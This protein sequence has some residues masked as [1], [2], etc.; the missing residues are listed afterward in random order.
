MINI[1]EET[2]QFLDQIIASIEKLG[3]EAYAQPLEIFNQSTLGQHFRHIYDF[4]LCLA[5]GAEQGLI[6]YAAR[7]REP[8][9]ELL[10][11]KA[12]ERFQEIQQRLVALDM[13]QPL[14]VVPDS[15]KGKASLDYSVASSVGREMMYAY[16]HGIHHLA[17]IK[18][19]VKT[20]F[21]GVELPKDLGVAPSTLR[22]REE[23]QK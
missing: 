9:I 21:P 20:A 16:D 10:P 13:E 15:Y 23:Q 4:Y 6:D 19:G 18:I 17:I 11:Q 2:V 1:K 8:N 3:A 5:E 22:Y 7:K 14:R 12:V